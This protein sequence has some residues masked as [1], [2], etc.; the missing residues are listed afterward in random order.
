MLVLLVIQIISHYYAHD[1]VYASACSHLKI[2]TW[3]G[4]FLIALL[5]FLNELA[6][7]F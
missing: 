7:M 5:Y 3:Q 4:T 6:L 1:L 2:F